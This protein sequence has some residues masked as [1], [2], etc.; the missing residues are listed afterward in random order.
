MFDFPRRWTVLV[1]CSRALLSSALRCKLWSLK[2]KTLL[3]LLSLGPTQPGTQCK[4]SPLSVRSST[5]RQSQ[6]QPDARHNQRAKSQKPSISFLFF[7]LSPLLSPDSY[8]PLRGAITV[9]VTIYF[10]HFM[11]LLPSSCLDIMPEQRRPGRPLC[12]SQYNSLSSPDFKEFPHRWE[13]LLWRE[14]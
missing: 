12:L 13:K 5:H 2:K 6:P 11:R 1:C 4:N 10:I 7:S 3:I 8:S 9:I 14:A